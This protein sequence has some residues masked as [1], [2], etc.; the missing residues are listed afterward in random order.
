MKIALFTLD[1]N[2]T[3]DNVV[4]V[5]CDDNKIKIMVDDD[6]KTITLENVYQL[7]ISK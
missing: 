6:I 5:L 7:V 2:F 3:F 1:D 4:K